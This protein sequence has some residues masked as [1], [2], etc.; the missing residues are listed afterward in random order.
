M[1]NYESGKSIDNFAKKNQDNTKNYWINRKYKN[2]V[3]QI[4]ELEKDFK[5]LTD[6]ELR[7]HNFQLQT[8]YKETKNLNNLI[9]RSFALTREV[10]FRTLGLRHFDVQ[11]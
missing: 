6:T 1:E 4:N 8:E 5:I 11:L 3:A 2:L 9:T 10:S 7:I